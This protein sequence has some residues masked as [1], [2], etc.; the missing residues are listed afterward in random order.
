MPHLFE[1]D[2]DHVRMVTTDGHRL[3]KAEVLVKGTQTNASM[4]IPLKG[5]LSILKLSVHT[6]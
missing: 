6:R 5:V 1:W 2:G 4:L 3:S